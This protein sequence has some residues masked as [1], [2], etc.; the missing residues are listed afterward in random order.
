MKN[1]HLDNLH[2]NIPKLES[3]LGYEPNDKNSIRIWT[4]LNEIENFESNFFPVKLSSFLEFD[5]IEEISNE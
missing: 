5:S 1:A 4:K 3:V 2:F